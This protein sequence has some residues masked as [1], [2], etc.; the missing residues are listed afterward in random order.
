MWAY[1]TLFLLPL[2]KFTKEIKIV[3]DKSLSHFINITSGFE[4]FCSV[5]HKATRTQSVSPI[6]CFQC[7]HFIHKKCANIRNWDITNIHKHLLT[8]ECSSCCINSLS[9][10]PFFTL[11]DCDV[12]NFSYNSSFPCKCSSTA[13]SLSDYSH[14][15]Q[16][17][18]CKL[19]FKEHE[20]LLKTI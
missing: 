20:V 13:I 6:P 7:H 17:E 3:G 11:E 16:L 1:S 15:E 5:C 8:W 18:T 19:T 2:I 10:L 14:L 9:S 4:N 12:I